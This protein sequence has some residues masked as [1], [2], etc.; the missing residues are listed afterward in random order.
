MSVCLFLVESSRVRSLAL[1]GS[2]LT[3]WT[4]NSDTHCFLFVCLFV[5]FAGRKAR[6]RMLRG[7]SCMFVWLFMCVC[8]AGRETRTCI[9]QVFSCL[10]SCLFACLFACLFV[11][12]AG[13]KSRTRS[14]RRFSY[15]FVR[16]FESSLA[17]SL[18]QGA[19]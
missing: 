8:F 7:F 14:L 2:E 12:H 9:L 17:R 19:S 3:R 10:F 5:C 15:L 18:S 6:T 16:L 11:C 1:P 13:R 4:D